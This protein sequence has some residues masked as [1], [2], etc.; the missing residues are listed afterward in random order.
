MLSYLSG[1]ITWTIILFCTSVICGPAITRNEWPSYINRNRVE[2]IKFNRFVSAVLIAA[3]P[4][5]RFIIELL[6]FFTAFIHVKEFESW[7]HRDV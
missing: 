7:F 6:L 1:V 5:F 3:V 2:P 4:G